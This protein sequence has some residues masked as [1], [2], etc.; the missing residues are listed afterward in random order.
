M[1]C[2]T[3]ED[4]ADAY[5]DDELDAALSAEVRQHLS[6]CLACAEAHTA[7]VAL[8]DLVRE[9]ALHYRAPDALRDRVRATLRHANRPPASPWRWIGI[10]AAILLAAS[11]AWNFALFRSRASFAD[12]IAQDVLSSHVRSL[13]GSHLLDVPSTDQHTV[14]PW[15]NGKLDFS[16]DVKD[17][18]AQGFPLIGGRVDYLGGHPVAALVFQRRHHIIN[19]FTWPASGTGGGDG[20]QNGY[21]LIH[22]DRGGMTYWAVSDLGAGELRQFAAL[23]QQP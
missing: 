4:L 11:L 6:T 22:W 2:R 1:T 13:I 16:P 19:L 8:R 5:L 23:Y 10:A 15:F 14:K 17:L 18:A 12:R 3:F 9:H 21:H 20:S 7:Q